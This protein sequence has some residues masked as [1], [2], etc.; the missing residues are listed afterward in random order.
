MVIAARDRSGVEGLVGVGFFPTNMR[1]VVTDMSFMLMCTR[2]FRRYTD[3]AN[4]RGVSNHEDLEG[5][6]LLINQS[7]SRRITM[8][9]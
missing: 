2:F 3:A 9:T 5:D 7:K 4:Y 1:V 6:R 8:L